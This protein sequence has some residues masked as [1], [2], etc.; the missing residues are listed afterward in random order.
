MKDSHKNIKY[1]IIKKRNSIEYNKNNSLQ[2]IHPKTIF[3]A[4]IIGDK[5]TFLSPIYKTNNITIWGVLSYK[6]MDKIQYNRRKIGVW[7]MSALF[8]S[9]QNKRRHLCQTHTPKKSYY[10][11]FQN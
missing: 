8:N 10:A 2:H 4:H 3:I 6:I 5:T 1:Q 11:P 9:S 7:E